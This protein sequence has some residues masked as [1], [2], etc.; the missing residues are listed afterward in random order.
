MFNYVRIHEIINKYS[1]RIAG[2]FCPFIFIFPTVWIKT[3][4]I[5]FIY[6]F[7]IIS[8]S[9]FLNT[10][11][12]QLEKILSKYVIIMISV[13][14]KTNKMQQ[15]QNEYDILANMITIL[16]IEN[17]NIRMKNYYSSFIFIFVNI[18]Q[19]DSYIHSICLIIINLL[20]LF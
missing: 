15:L 13:K 20:F 12:Q 5:N 19:Y 6:I 14:I 4:I 2:W 8:Y 18:L 7:F 9:Y 17:K 1:C 10:F 16:I 3:K 11:Q